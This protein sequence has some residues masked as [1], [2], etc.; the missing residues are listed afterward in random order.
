MVL[1]QFQYPLFNG[2]FDLMF[3]IF[4]A[5]EKLGKAR[6]PVLLKPCKPLATG[7]RAYS[8]LLANLRKCFLPLPAS[9]NKLFLFVHFIDL[10]PVHCQILCLSIWL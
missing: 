3:G 6:R 10:L 7:L 8:K 5:R 2:L 1:F 4:G 9:E